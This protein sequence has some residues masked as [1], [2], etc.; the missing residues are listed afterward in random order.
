MQKLKNAS[1]GK[2]AIIILCIVLAVVLAGIGVVYA[3]TGRTTEKTNTIKAQSVSVE[4]DEEVDSF[5]YTNGGTNKKEVKFTNTS[6]AAVFL[7]VSYTEMMTRV[8]N[9][10]ETWLPHNDAARTLN[11]T[12]YWTS[13]W[14]DGG[15]GWYY[16]KKILPKGASTNLVL[17]SVSIHGVDEYAQMRYTLWFSAEVVQCSDEIAV[18]TAALRDLFDKSATVS[19]MVV[20]S[21]GAVTSGNVTWGN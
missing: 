3:Y 9:A 1:R 21:N 12:T 10:E 8:E 17:S 14:T 7:R 13:E 18:N 15:D 20:N 2:L 19:S 11:W 4:V 16:Y 6:E 5:T